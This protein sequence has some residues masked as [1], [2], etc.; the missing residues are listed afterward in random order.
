VKFHYDCDWLETER[1]CKRAL[2]LNPNYATA[3]AIH[4][5]FLNAVGRFDEAS[6]QIRHAQELDLL[7]LGI[8]TGYGLTYYFNRRFDDAITQYRKTLEL[9]PSFYVAR[10]NLASALLQ[11][12][13]YAAAAAEYEKVHE[14]MPS[15]V[16][17]A[18]E[19]GRLYA[20]MGRKHDALAMLDKVMAVSKTQY[21][22]APPVASIYSGLG[23]RDKAS[24]GWKRVIRSVRGLW[25]FSRWSRSTMRSE[26]TIVSRAYC[27][28]SAPDPAFTR[29]GCAIPSRIRFTKSSA[30]F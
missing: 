26:A 29:R 17:I 5:R 1:E 28:G 2:Q 15:D 27:S 7:A 13:D 9:D 16:S 22:N 14:Q 24:S 3:H 18:C 19:V 30:G 21:M 4:S 25:C 8:G 20:M 11:K 12:G 23:D 6:D 10:A